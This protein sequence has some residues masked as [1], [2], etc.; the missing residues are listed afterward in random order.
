[1]TSVHPFRFIILKQALNGFFNETSALK[2]QINNYISFICK[3][4]IYR[5]T[6]YDR[7]MTAKKIHDK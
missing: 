4:S 1:M 3:A 7:S 5:V 2:S 6:K